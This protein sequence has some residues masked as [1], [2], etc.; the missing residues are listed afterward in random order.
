MTKVS[1]IMA[2][3]KE[4]E[5]Y[6]RAAIESILNQTFKDFEYIII[7]DN[8]D[9]LLHISIIQE[10][11][12]KDK[13]VR[14]FINKINKGLTYSLNKGLK[15]ACGEY[16]CRMDADD[17]SEINRI[18]LQLNYLKN[19]DY[20][21]IGGITQIIDEND[22]SIYS[23]K[24]VPHDFN[25]IKKIIRYNQCIAHPTWFGKKQLFDSLEGYRDIPLCEDYDFTLR[26]I[27]KGYKIS[28]INQQLLKY[29]MTENS[30]S[31]NNLY[32]QFLYAKYITKCY[33]HGKIANIDLAKKYVK[34]RNSDIKNKRYSKANQKFN[35]ALSLLEEKKYFMCFKSCII[36]PFISMNYLKKIYRL[37]MVQINSY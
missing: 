3:Y 24:T 13:R 29:R 33:S 36:I 9:N 10:Y 5:K 21:L 2:T 20:D 30:I 26:A 23:I 25:K 6:L 19:N 1:V 11:M 12:K 16:I 32:K 15:N 8:P 18:E 17:I 37:V 35:L 31:R 27:L 4:E 34:S 7:L 28:N 22:R 14:F